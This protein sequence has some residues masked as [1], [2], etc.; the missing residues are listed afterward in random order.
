[1][2]FKPFVP[3]T[4]V[5]S[6]LI[7]LNRCNHGYKPSVYCT[8]F[9]HTI[10]VYNLYFPPVCGLTAEGAGQIIKA[11]STNILRESLWESH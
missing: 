6:E 5:T 4:D 8:L 10:N 1:M 11:I 7:S 9:A 2:S 3:T